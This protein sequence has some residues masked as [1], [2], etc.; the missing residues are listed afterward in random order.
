M[1]AHTKSSRARRGS[2]SQAQAWPQSWLWCSLSRDGAVS[3][4][5]ASA[6]AHPLPGLMSEN[7]VLTEHSP[8]PLHCLVRLQGLTSNDAVSPWR[9][10]MPLPRVWARSG[11]T[12]ALTIKSL[13]FGTSLF[14]ADGLS[15]WLCPC[16][17]LQV[18]PVAGAPQASLVTGPADRA[19][20][21]WPR[22]KR[23]AFGVLPHA[24]ASI[25]QPLGG[26]GPS[27]LPE[28]CCSAADQIPS[29]RTLPVSPTLG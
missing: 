5:Q 17:P 15:L 28:A 18:S 1:Q 29:S 7:V 12:G 23:V 22:G 11:G 27:C 25:S 19:P 6:D 9:L 2:F 21:T 26:Y 14:P 8:A 20:C 4:P 24:P 13:V 10:S 3:P 16:K